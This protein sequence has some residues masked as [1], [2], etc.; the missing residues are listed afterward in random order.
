MSRQPTV[1]M[2]CVPA[3]VR[4]GTLPGNLQK[5]NRAQPRWRARPK[6]FVGQGSVPPRNLPALTIRI[7]MPRRKRSTECS[8]KPTRRYTLCGSYPPLRP[9]ATLE[10]CEL[11]WCRWTS[12]SQGPGV[13]PGNPA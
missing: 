11:A 6:I 2:L 3:L 7:L 5:L 10:L 12:K 8:H 13:F 9:Q 4:S 1:G